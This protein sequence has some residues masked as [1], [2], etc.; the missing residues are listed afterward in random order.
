MN[1][2]F[3]AALPDLDKVVQLKP[4]FTAARIQRGNVLLKQGD[5]DSAQQDFDSVVSFLAIDQTNKGV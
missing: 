2:F 1:L 4:D 5:L 3:Q